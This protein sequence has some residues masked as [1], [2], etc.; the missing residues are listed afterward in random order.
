MGAAELGHA[1]IVAY[2]ELGSAKACDDIETEVGQK[3]AASIGKPHPMPPDI[4]GPGKFPCGLTVE[5]P[6]A[7]LSPAQ[8]ALV[9]KQSHYRKALRYDDGTG[10][11]LEV[12]DVIDALPALTGAKVQKPALSSKAQALVDAKGSAALAAVQA[13]AGG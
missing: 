4:V 10:G 12:D 6:Y 3:Y 5:T 13:L 1:V 8:Q 7:Q 9:F 11:V 2:I